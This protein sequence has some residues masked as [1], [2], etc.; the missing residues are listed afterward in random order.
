MLNTFGYFDYKSGEV[1]IQVMTS[2]SIRVFYVMCKT[3]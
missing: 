1:E 3:L 2:I